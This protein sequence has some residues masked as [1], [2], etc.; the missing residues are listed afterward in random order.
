MKKTIVLAA[1]LL[2]S[3]AS[4]AQ[5]ITGFVKYDYDRATGSPWVSAHRTLVGG[6]YKLPENFGSVDVA[7]A[8]SELVTN[9]VQ[10][11]YGAEIGY[12]NGVKVDIV[13][14]TGRVAYQAVTDTNTWRASVEGSVP[15]D[16]TFSGFVG[17]EYLDTKFKGTGYQ[18]NRYTI[19]TDIDLD[20]RTSIR[21]GYAYLNGEGRGSNGL[22]T[23]INYRF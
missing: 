22:T 12:S 1:L 19:G 9:V 5:Q 23:A 14:L 21:V 16:K 13:T 3:A 11:G 20:T 2:A 10:T 7:G 4:F 15:F 18:F 8:V 17:Y 6:A